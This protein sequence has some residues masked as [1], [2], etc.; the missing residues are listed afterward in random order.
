[1][2]RFWL[3]TGGLFL[4]L[5]AVVILWNS[6]FWYTNDEDNVPAILTQIAAV[7]LI[8]DGGLVAFLGEEAAARSTV[9]SS[10]VS[11]IR[12]GSMRREPAKT[13]KPPPNNVGSRT[14]TE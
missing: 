2:R 13:G 4:A 1:M 8:V 3:F 14:S 7:A 12:I 9:P 5:V 6:P 11:S 10:S